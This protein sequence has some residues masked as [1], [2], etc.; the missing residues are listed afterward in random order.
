MNGILTGHNVFEVKSLN[1]SLNKMYAFQFSIT[2]RRVGGGGGGGFEVRTS[3][4]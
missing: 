4:L 3:P 1:V 2:R